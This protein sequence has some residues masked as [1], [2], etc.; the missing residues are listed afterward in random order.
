MQI[1][2]WKYYNHAAIPTTAPHEPVNMKP[3][4]DGTIW[5]LDGKP[6]L[7]RWHTDWDCGYETN[8][9]YIICDAPFDIENISKKS[10]KNIRKSLE[11]CE[12]RKVDAKDCIDDLWRV[13]QEATER[14]SNYE[15][16]T[17][18]D[19]FASMIMQAPDYWEIWCGYEKET[20]RM[21]GF[22]ICSVYD[23]WVDFTTSKY[24]T[25]YLKLRV[26]DALNYVVLEEYL[27]IRGK[28]Y[29]SNGTR[30][31]VH[32]TNVQDY[33]QEHFNFRKSYC[34]LRIRYGFP[35]NMIIGVLYPFRKSIEK[36]D[37]GIT[38]KICS[39]LSMEEIAR[40]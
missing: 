34:K 33:Y 18:R 8:W 3:L 17:T 24:S 9:W 6:L 11:N 39:L 19:G 1:E 20:N 31:V 35:F 30:S 25:E 37:K 21:I 36:Y 28:K 16:T 23:D 10:R 29:I 38:H 40:S 15:Q 13:F 2:G 7:A 14:Y 32:E 5:K 12:V 22:K 4:E 26:S 27:N